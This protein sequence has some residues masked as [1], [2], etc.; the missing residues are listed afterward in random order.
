MSDVDL[1]IEELEREIEERER[2]L[3]ALRAFKQT[4]SSNAPVASARGTLDAD[5]FFVDAA[6]ETELHDVPALARDILD[7]LP[8]QIFIKN[9]APTKGRGRPYRYLNKIVRT[10]TKWTKPAAA[11]HDD[12]AFVDGV[13][14]P[15]WK[16][17]FKGE[18]ETIR[19]RQSAKRRLEWAHRTQDG[20]VWRINTV[21]EIPIVLRSTQEVIAF[22]ALAQDIDFKAFGEAHRQLRAI[23]NHEYGNLAN[24]VRGDVDTAIDLIEDV[25]TGA[26]RTDTLSETTELLVRARSRLLI[27]R[28][29]ADAMFQAMY[30][31][32]NDSVSGV[33]GKVVADLDAQVFTPRLWR[34]TSTVEP[35]VEDCRLHKPDAIKAVLIQLIQNA[36]KHTDGP[37]SAKEITLRVRRR[38]S[39][40]VWEIGNHCPN[41]KRVLEFERCLTTAAEVVGGFG[42][43]VIRD[44]LCHCLEIDDPND[45]IRFPDKPDA[46]GWVRVEFLTEEVKV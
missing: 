34:L 16:K 35:G 9:A 22:C 40:I 10:I 31:A 24:E 46:D 12:E 2:E 21:D 33:V 30:C 11:Y 18:T 1:K 37:L 41:M 8:V 7:R 19:S 3:A 45:A 43:Q 25:G 4:E 17:M 42:A 44:I 28:K 32:R 14:D 36:E 29:V 26:K 27:A 20:V 38:A 6:D 23:M 39:H 15:L 5:C 13:T